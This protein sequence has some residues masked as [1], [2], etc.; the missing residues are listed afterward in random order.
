MARFPKSGKT[1]LR[2]DDVISRPNTKLGSLVKRARFLIHLET[3]IRG[4]LDP[5][6]AAQFQVVAARKN[7][8]ILISPTA[9]WATRLRMHTP[10]LINSLHSVGMVDIEHIDIRVAPLVRQERV[11]RS[12]R[13]LSSAAKQALDHM[14]QFKGGDKE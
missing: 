12:R 1:I 8:L 2:V 6:L 3:L 10:Q 9:T 7:R 5:D 4:F 13:S 11:S 14:A